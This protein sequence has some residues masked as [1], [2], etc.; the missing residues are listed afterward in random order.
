[1]LAVQAYVSHHLRI[2]IKVTSFA[3]RYMMVRF[4]FNLDSFVFSV[5]VETQ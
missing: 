1:M 2:H 5:L 4:I 3:E